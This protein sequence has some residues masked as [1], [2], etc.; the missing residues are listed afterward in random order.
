MRRWVGHRRASAADAYVPFYHPGRDTPW[1]TAHNS[2]FLGNFFKRPLSLRPWS[3]RSVGSELTFQTAEAAFQATKVLNDALAL[4]QLQSAADGDEALRIS[5]GHANMDF[6]YGFGY[7][8]PS[9][10]PD[11]DAMLMV[12]QSK[13]QDEELSRRLLETGHAFLL[14]H[15][16]KEGRDK[17]WSDNNDGTGQNMLGEALMATR[18]WL[19]G[20]EDWRRKRSAAPDWQRQVAQYAALTRERFEGESAWHASYGS[21][22]EPCVEGAACFRAQLVDGAWRPARSYDGRSGEH[23]GKSCKA[24]HCAETDTA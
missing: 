6:T 15:N 2:G 14:E 12:L 4:K 10:S 16:D 22:V 9:G 20:E 11:Y 13:F 24:W 7:D 19:R 1:D 23:C 17:K 18:A 21:G 3:G 8:S 5:R